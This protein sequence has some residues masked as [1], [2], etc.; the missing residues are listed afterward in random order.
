MTEQS[1]CVLY[2]SVNEFASEIVCVKACLNRRLL[3]WAIEL[4]QKLLLIVTTFIF[5]PFAGTTTWL[6]PTHSEAKVVVLIF[7]CCVA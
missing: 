7:L 5:F 3:N 6:L 4:N 2:E 1:A